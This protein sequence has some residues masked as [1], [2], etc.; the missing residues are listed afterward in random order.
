MSS[1]KRLDWP[2]V[3][4][5]WF[6]DNLVWSDL[7]DYTLSCFAWVLFIIWIVRPFLSFSGRSY[8]FPGWSLA[9]N[10]YSDNFEK[11]FTTFIL[12]DIYIF[13]SVYPIIE[14]IFFP[15]YSV[16]ILFFKKFSFFFLKISIYL[17][18]GERLDIAYSYWSSPRE[19]F[20]RSLL[21]G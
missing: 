19:E 17:D 9:Y 16:L 15:D 13:S 20:G 5:V 3:Y 21:R 12:R 7:A 1:I 18:K 2:I 6:K 8:V 10:T 4:E 11:V 14:L